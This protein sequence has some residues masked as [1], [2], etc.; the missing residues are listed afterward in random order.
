MTAQ[1]YMHDTHGCHG[2]AQKIYMLYIIYC[3]YMRAKKIPYQGKDANDTHSM[4]KNT[5]YTHS[6]YEN[7][8]GTHILSMRGAQ[9]IHIFYE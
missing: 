6:K 4:Y 1:V 7:T 3:T 2:M 9:M 5:N 8:N